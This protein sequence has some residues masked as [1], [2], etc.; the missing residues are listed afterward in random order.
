MFLF[1]KYA[2]PKIIQ[3]IWI[4]QISLFDSRQR[5]GIFFFSTRTHTAFKCIPWDLPRGNMAEA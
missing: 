4:T 1:R 2:Y 5:N 3:V